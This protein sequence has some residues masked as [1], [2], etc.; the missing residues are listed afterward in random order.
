[1]PPD[2]PRRRRWPWI[3]A[4]LVLLPLVAG[5]VALASF[6]LNGQK[7][8]IQA[9]VKERT[10]R[11]LALN[12]PIG[13]KL[14]LIPT[15]T[16]EDVALSNMPGGSQPQM[17]TL[18]RAEV[19][20]ALLPL[21]SRRVEVARLRLVGPDLLLETDAEGRPNW[22]LAPPAAPAAPPPAEAAPAASPPAA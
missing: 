21:L 11:D 7:P 2:T 9:L 20:L 22:V 8:R 6:D 16:V 13:L 3:L 5:A 17:L 15:V 4:L 10:G 14:S 1:M 19:Q 12:G 18:R